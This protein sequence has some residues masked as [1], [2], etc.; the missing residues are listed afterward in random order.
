MKYN[1][2]FLSGDCFYILDYVNWYFDLNSKK[3]SNI[4]MESL[5][6]HH[7]LCFFT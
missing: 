5:K 7:Q 6:A 3:L 1:K 2:M 4:Y